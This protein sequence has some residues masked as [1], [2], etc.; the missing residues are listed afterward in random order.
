MSSVEGEVWR[1]RR[2][3]TKIGTVKVSVSDPFQTIRIRI[4]VAPKTYQN[5]EKN[6][7]KNTIHEEKI[8]LGA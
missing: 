7:L 2:T 4:R 5:H 6:V 8:N 3:V 1:K